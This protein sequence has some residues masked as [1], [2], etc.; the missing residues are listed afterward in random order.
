MVILVGSVLFPVLAVH[1]SLDSNTPGMLVCHATL[2]VNASL[3]Q[4][5]VQKLLSELV[6]VQATGRC[7][8]WSV[9]FL[10]HFCQHT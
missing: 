5:K 6:T 1:L 3:S 8:K 2:C 9:S 10:T 4:R 7:G